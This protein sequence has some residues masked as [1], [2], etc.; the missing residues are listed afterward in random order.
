ML[1]G[2]GPKMRKRSGKL[3]AYRSIENPFLPI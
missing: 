3:H 1:R 2:H